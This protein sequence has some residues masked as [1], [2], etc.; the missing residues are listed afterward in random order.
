T[1]TALLTIVAVLYICPILWM[2]LGSLKNQRDIFSYVPKVRFSPTLDNYR[3]LTNASVALYQNMENSLVVALASSIIALALGTWTAFVLANFR[4]A[5]QRD[6]EFWILSMRMIP[7]LSLI[8]PFYLM[9]TKLNLF[10]TRTGLVLVYLTFNIPLVVW[11][12]KGF[13][14]DIPKDL[15]EAAKVDG[16]GVMGLFFRISLPLVRPGLVA[17]FL[18]C[19]MTSWNEFPFAQ[20]LTSRSAVTMPV[21]ITGFNTQNGVLWG[22]ML[23]AGTVAVIPVIILSVAIRKHLVRGLTMGSS[24]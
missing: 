21:A 10:D 5:R 18:L 3:Y 16:S 23:A 24:K 7:P 11:L 19:V 4:V 12:L 9:F 1:S 22:P 13:F 6:F 14:S 8:V 20:Y 2:V 17:A 15:A